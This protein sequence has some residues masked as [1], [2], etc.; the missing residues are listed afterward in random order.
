MAQKENVKILKSAKPTVRI[1]DGVVKKWDVEVVL[2][3]P[4]SGWNR[5]YSANEDVEYL[6]KQPEEFTQAELFSYLSDSIDVI[7]S[8]HW[9]AHNTPPVD[10]QIEFDITNLAV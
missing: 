10:E 6:G 3:E 7:F 9:D 8:A 4:V 2:T 5:S 1:A